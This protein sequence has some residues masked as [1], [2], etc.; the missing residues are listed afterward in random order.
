VTSRA[1]IDTNVWVYT[2]DDSEPAKQARAR[3]VLEPEP[4]KDLVVSAQVLGEFYVTVRRKLAQTL[5]EPEA[6]ALVERMRRLPVVPVDSSLVAAAIANARDWKLSYWDALI[7]AAAETAGCGI[8]L[9]ED[10]T[11]GQMYG[12]VRVEDPFRDGAA[13]EPENGG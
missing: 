10:L 13:A 3:L 2:V 4:G 1:F 11:H 8:L 9:S 7:V 5:A 6:A 12:M